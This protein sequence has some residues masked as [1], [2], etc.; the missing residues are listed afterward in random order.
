M[1]ALITI[2]IRLPGGQTLAVAD[3]PAAEWLEFAQRYAVEAA[4]KE[5]GR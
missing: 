3:M 1:S 5:A 4:K 2:T